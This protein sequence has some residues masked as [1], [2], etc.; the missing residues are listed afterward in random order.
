MREKLKKG[1]KRMI[2]G[3][4]GRNKRGIAKGERMG[5]EEKWSIRN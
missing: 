3:N 4:E 1:W 5:R 2:E